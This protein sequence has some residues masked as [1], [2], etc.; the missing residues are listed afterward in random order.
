[1]ALQKQPPVR[2]KGVD[3]RDAIAGIGDAAWG[4]WQ[5]ICWESKH[6]RTNYIPSYA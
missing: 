3:G 6:D 4:S 2:L 1:M 5:L